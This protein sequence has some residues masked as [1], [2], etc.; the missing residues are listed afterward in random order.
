MSVN[1]PP[2]Q[3]RAVNLDATPLVPV[4]ETKARE[5]WRANKAKN[6]SASIEKAATLEAHKAMAAQ[7]I[8]R[9]E[10]VEG[11]I[12][13]EAVIEGGSEDKVDTA[14]LYALVTSGEITL[15]QFVSVVTA[16]QGAVKTTLGTNIL[17]KVLTTKA[18]EATLKI[19]QK[20]D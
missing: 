8:G 18:K 15:P 11:N 9:F 17:A 1:P 7:N 14:K 2:R 4:H 13:V 16:T 10:F 3:R 6:A 12:T 5:A 19:R 20:K